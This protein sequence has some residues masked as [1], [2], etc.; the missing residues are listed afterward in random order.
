MQKIFQP[1]CRFIKRPLAD[2]EK[3]A[4][5]QPNPGLVIQQLSS[6]IKGL[7]IMSKMNKYL[8]VARMG[9]PVP[10]SRAQNSVSSPFSPE[11][12]PSSETSPYSPKSSPQY[13]LSSSEPSSDS[14]ETPPQMSRSTGGSPSNDNWPDC[15]KFSNLN[16][17]N[18]ELYLKEL[19]EL[20]ERIKSSPQPSLDV[21]TRKLRRL[22]PD[23]RK[24]S[25]FRW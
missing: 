2:H 3:F 4:A 8:P 12:S 17:L 22:L 11:K 14:Q 16:R 21:Q 7:Y 5:P 6:C 18:I 1:A 25:S 19:E 10:V 24:F 13:P 15:R 20:E 23:Y 9:Y